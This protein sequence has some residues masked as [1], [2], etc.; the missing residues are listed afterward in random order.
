MTFL[1]RDEEWFTRTVVE[2]PQITNKTADGAVESYITQYFDEVGQPLSR[3][4]TDD[5]PAGSSDLW[6]TH[7]VRDV[8]NGWIDTI[9]SPANVTG[10]THNEGGGDPDGAFTT[11]TSVGL[12]T[13]FLRASSGDL[14]GF[15]EVVKHREGT[16]GDAYL[17]LTLTHTTRTL[18]TGDADVVR[19]LIASQRIYTTEITSGTTDSRLTSIDYT[20]HEISTKTDV[21]YIT[22]E[23]IKTT[24]PLV[25]TA[26][27]GSNTATTSN[28]FLNETGQTEW[29][30]STDGKIN[31][32]LYIDESGSLDKSIQ[33]A[34]TTHADFSGITI[35]TGFAS[36]G[37]DELHIVS[38]FGYVGGGG[39]G[40][41]DGGCSSGAGGDSITTG[42]GPTRV[43]Y[44]ARLKDGR[45]IQ[46]SF[47]NFDDATPDKYYGP[48]GCSV[49]NHAGQV[50][51]QGTIA[52]DT[53]GGEYTTE[54]PTDFVDEEQDDMI[55][56]ISHAGNSI[57]NLEQISTRVYDETGGQVSESRFYFKPGLGSFPGSE[58]TD[59]DAT[60]FGYNDQG[61]SVRTEDPTGQI[62]RTV[63]DS[64]GRTTQSWTGTN[65]NA[66]DGGSSGTDN[67]VK[68]V[69]LVYDSAGDEANSYLTKQTLFVENSA[70]DD[71]ETTFQHDLRGR[72]LLTTNPAA[73]HVLTMYDN[74]GR[75]LASGLYSSTASIVVGTDIPTTE[76]TNRLA[77]SQTYFDERE[78][79]KSSFS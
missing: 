19:P 51:S 25:T 57:G 54:V 18:E 40:S 11:S 50:E 67:M 77:L 61:R 48:V 75:Q 12:V 72:V 60:F 23:T 29:T 53:N 78:P 55:S 33:D 28:I 30:K 31:Y 15:L 76:T 24:Y 17:D 6:A 64:L 70:T 66:F 21:L 44:R 68:T 10:Y 62:Q 47:P 38:C 65:D 2:Q 13:E 8:T 34:D 9:H 7:V 73:P 3:V 5:D 14:V 69:E 71:R 63:F 32:W 52:L 49:I 20:W 74:L 45:V 27:N 22:P 4:L 39:M 37:N 42:T 36:D 79:G 43:T 59:Y 58:G 35:P 56:A 46:L 1:V 41:P 16:T 26:N